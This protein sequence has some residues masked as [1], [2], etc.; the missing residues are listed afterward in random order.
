MTVPLIDRKFVHKRLDENV[1]V[2]EP[3]RSTGDEFSAQSFFP[4]RH[5]FYNDSVS[6]LGASGYL[7]EVG[8]QANLALS[9][10][11]FD[12]PLEA[13]FLVTSIDWRFPAQSPFVVRELSDFKVF[14]RVENA[15]RRKGAIGKLET[16]VHCVQG[17]HEFFTGRASFL[18]A[19][20]NLTQRGA[21][22]LPTIH[23][24]GRLKPSP[25]EVQVNDPRN[26]L[27]EL[28]RES[29]Y[30]PGRLAM[31]LDPSHPFFFE[32]ENGHVPGMMLLEAGKQAAVHSATQAF[33]MVSGLYGDL[34]SGEI[35]FGRFA[36]L[37][38]TVWMTS[39]FGALEETRTGYRASVEIAFEQA[40]KEVGRI[41]GS[42][43][44]TD[45]AEVVQASAI[46]N[47]ARVPPLA[48]SNARSF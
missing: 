33:P 35:R 42:V 6:G 45:T 39:S 30:R 5:P 38:R 10:R 13:G 34:D 3:A 25:S 18:I 9:H 22:L 28:P 40:N 15:M 17:E 27:V 4:T 29:E 23:L 41:G 36:E 32:H 48:R 7:V 1:F 12:V 19:S 46:W 20:R 16:R 43:A 21:A 2:G 14:I 24:S 31:H 11:F 37:D 47:A 44:F 8:R 26:V